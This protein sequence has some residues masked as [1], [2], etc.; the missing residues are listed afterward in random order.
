[1]RLSGLPDPPPS[2]PHGDDA[3]ALIRKIEG[4]MREGGRR[5]RFDP[6]TRTFRR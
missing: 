2:D 3:A 5:L 1:V 4:W 6:A